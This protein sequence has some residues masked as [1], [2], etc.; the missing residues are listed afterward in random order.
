[1]PSAKDGIVVWQVPF[2]K[3]NDAL[4]RC[5]DQFFCIAVLAERLDIFAMKNCMRRKP[6]PLV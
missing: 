5:F 2:K 6:L 4:D 3:R 1:M